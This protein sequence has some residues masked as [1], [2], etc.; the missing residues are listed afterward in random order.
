MPPLEAPPDSTD[1]IE[2]VWQHSAV[3]LFVLRTCAAEPSIQFD[4][5][6][7]AATAKICRRLE[8]YPIGD[9]A[10]GS[11]RN[12]A[13]RGST[14][15]ANSMSVSVCL[16]TAAAPRRH[17]Q[18]SLRATLDWNDASLPQAERAV[19]RRLSIWALLYDRRG[20]RDRR[21]QRDDRV[22]RGALLGKSRGEISCFSGR[23]RSSSTLSAVR[24]GTRLRDGQAH[25]MRRV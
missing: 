15:V 3:Q 17:G 20:E 10:R 16:R 1:D 6:I 4:A 5:R 12:R 23:Q 8:R 14:R 2:E 22:R 21:E 19:M 7:A 25:G 18:Q 11:E 9:R 24:V 13:G